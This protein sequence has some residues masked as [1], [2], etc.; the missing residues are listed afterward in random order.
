MKPDLRL[1]ALLDPAVAGGRAL[2]ALAKLIAPSATLVQ[3]RDKRGAT[4]A[5]VEEARALKAV[6]APAGIPLLVNDRVDVALAALA[7]GV[8]IGPT[9]MAPQD[10]RRLLGPDA[11]I[12]L[13]LKS[14]AQA[15]AAPLDLLDYVAV[16]GV[17]ATTS[18]D[19]AQAPIGTA[20]LKAIV[21]AV[22]ARVPDYPVCAIA[23]INAANAA[24]V[25]AAGADGVSVISALSL[26]DNPA[27]AARDLRA[28]VDAALQKRAGA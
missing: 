9:D 24:D 1:Y 10:A 5:M 18:K 8:H 2:P 22:R 12:G 19:D 20:G 14:V 21:D 4:H 16:G 23:G 7:D 3:L 6:L 13:S 17:Y 27:Q 26:T 15:Q 25:I 28:V 11:I